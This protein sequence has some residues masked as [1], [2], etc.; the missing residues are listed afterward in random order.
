MTD[1]TFIHNDFYKKRDVEVECALMCPS[2]HNFSKHAYADIFVH[3]SCA[4]YVNAVSDVNNFVWHMMFRDE[5]AFYMNGHVNRHSCHFCG[6][7][8]R[9]KIY[10]YMQDPQ[11]VNMWCGIMLGAENRVV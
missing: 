6:Q 1:L 2:T 5:A 7:K 8:W 11:E 9:Y 10:E 4:R 3:T